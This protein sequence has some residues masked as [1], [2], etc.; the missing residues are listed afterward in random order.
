M[1]ADPTIEALALDFGRVRSAVL[2]PE[3]IAAA[4]LAAGAAVA[5]FWGVRPA[6]FDG[7]A[8]WMKC[9]Y[10]VSV[11]AAALFLS[12]RLGKPGADCRAAIAL[13]LVPLGSAAV[14]VAFV[15]GTTPSS[16][17]L[18]D[19]L[20]RTWMTCSFSIVLL[21]ALITPL[22]ML[23]ARSLAPVRLHSAGAALG[24]A[25]GAVAATAYGA[26]YC[27]ESSA[28]FVATWYTL[29]IALAGA[30]GAAGGRLW[31]KW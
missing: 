13:L 17:W 15:L 2:R 26:L 18:T 6:L 3:L 21:S 4:A 5:L 7:S 9:G 20:G 27:A 1:N 16:E 29:G 14:S 10:T 19:L 24:V 12:R 28:L 30:I 8:P 22:V 23:A 25:A 11:A 31:L